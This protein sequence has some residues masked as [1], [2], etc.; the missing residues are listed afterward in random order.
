MQGSSRLRI[1]FASVLVGPSGP[2]RAAPVLKTGAGLTEG[3]T[4]VHY[5]LIGRAEKCGCSSVVEHLLAKERVE[6][7]NLFIRFETLLFSLILFPTFC[8]LS[9]ASDSFAA[10]IQFVRRSLVD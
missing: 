5:S 4:F 7:S 3:P 9:L 1:T 2:G 10:Q 6:S 8:L